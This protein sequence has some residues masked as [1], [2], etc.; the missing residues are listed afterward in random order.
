MFLLARQQKMKKK[1]K[2]KYGKDV[3]LLPVWKGNQWLG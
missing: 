2:L 3:Y 1:G